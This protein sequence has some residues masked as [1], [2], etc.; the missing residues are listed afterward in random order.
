M[1]DF[2]NIS[3]IEHAQY[4]WHHGTF[5]GSREINHQ[6]V[7]LYSVQQRFFEIHYNTQHFI[8]TVIEVDMETIEKYYYKGD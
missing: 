5:V 4:L 3:P 2:Y 7:S 8:K 1:K 6:K